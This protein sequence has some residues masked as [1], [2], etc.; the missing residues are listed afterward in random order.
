MS[1]LLS[2]ALRYA[3]LGYP[4][5]PCEP[6]TNRPATAHGFKDA[7]TNPAEIER[8]WAEIPRANIG[9][10]TAGLLV[11]DIDG[12]SNPWPGPERAMD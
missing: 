4:V 7:T 8:W 2:A 3:E 11:L 12:A 9:M 6:G 5:F 10:P 1:D